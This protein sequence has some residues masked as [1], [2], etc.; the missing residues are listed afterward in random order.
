M[1]KT[2]TRKLHQGQIQKRKNTE[3]KKRQEERRKEEIE[4]EAWADEKAKKISKRIIQI[5][6]DREIIERKAKLK[7]LYEKEL[8]EL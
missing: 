6:K 7:E 3:E 5:E 8:E 2:F 1:S 4:A